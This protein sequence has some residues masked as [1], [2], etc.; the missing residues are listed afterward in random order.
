MLRQPTDKD[1]YIIYTLLNKINITGPDIF[2]QGLDD[3][4]ILES[5]L[6][7]IG[8]MKK[9]F[10][11]VIRIP[12][13]F[14]ALLSF[15]DDFD[16][17]EL[18]A[19]MLEKLKKAPIIEG[20]LVFLTIN[21]QNHKA[22]AF[23][24]SNGFKVTTDGLEMMLDD[25]SEFK[26]SRIKDKIKGFD[27]EDLEEYIWLFDQAYNPT[28]VADGKPTNA[29]L[30]NKQKTHDMFAE[31]DEAGDFGG[32]WLDD[33]LVGAY[34]TRGPLILDIVVFPMYQRQGHGT[35]L[36]EHVLATVEGPS[37]L[38]LSRKNEAARRFFEK[39]GFKQ[40]ASHVDMVMDDR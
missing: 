25:T 21:G 2:E 11:T 32:Y 35:K 33:K 3:N 37:V 28:L 31:A 9:G 6:I 26:S 1:K 22:V 10:F 19:E 7:E 34:L 38:Y 27:P 15:E 8:G 40:S 14:L 13:G 17:P 5:W 18:F 24:E 39:Y 23:F 16:Q 20:Q 29:Y 36:L 12:D 30:R 4:A